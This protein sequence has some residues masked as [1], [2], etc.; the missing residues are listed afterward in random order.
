MCY[1]THFMLHNGKTEREEPELKI[2]SELI[3]SKEKMVLKFKTK[4]I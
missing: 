2:K 4:Q 3:C 1:I